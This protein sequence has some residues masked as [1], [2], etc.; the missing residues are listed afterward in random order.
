MTA[1]AAPTEPGKTAI[2][3]LEKVR[4][5]K[6][7]LEP[8][9]DTAL[10]A[11]TVTEKKQQI[12]RR[13]ERM[14]RDLGSDPLE[15][16]EVKLD[17]NFAAVLVRKIGGFDPSRLQ[18]FALALIKRDAKWTVAPVPASFENVG[19]GYAVALRKRLELLENWMLRS[20]VV[21]LEQLREQSLG[22]MRQEIEAKVSSKD[23]RHLDAKHF[24]EQ[25]LAACERKDLALMLGF[26]G[27][28]AAKLPENWSARLKAA[29]HAVAAGAEGTRPWR[30]LTA[31]EVLRVIVHHEEKNAAGL[32]SIA[33]LDPAGTG[34][35]SPAPQIELIHLELTKGDDG[36][37]QINPPAAFLKASQDPGDNPENPFDSELLEAFP[38]KW[39]ET[40]PSTPQASAELS[41]QNV[42]AALRNGNLPGLLALAKLDNGPQ[43]AS[44]ACIQAAQLWGAQHQ[45]ATV[46]HTMPLAFSADENSAVGILQFF[47][48]HEPDRLDSRAMY[49]E[50]SAS[51]WLWTPCPNTATQEKF[52]TWVES[53][54]Q[55]WSKKWQQQL[56]TDTV[57]LS[58]IHDNQA[59]TEE[60]ARTT[61]LA[62]LDATRHSD[63]EA[64]LRRIA[65]LDDP[66][67]GS[68]V[69]QN[70]GYE[71]LGSRRS[72]ENPL[73]TKIYQ[74]KTWTAVGVKI[75]Q[76]GK[77]SYP[78]Y[79][80]IQT[81][82]GPRILIEI[83]LFAAGNHGREFLNKAAFERLRKF[84]DATSELQ[85]LYSE[86][87]ANIEAMLAKPSP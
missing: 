3:F 52:K 24:G 70:L 14:A 87:Q 81:A 13:L 33:C 65:R 49:F 86:H 31:P 29:D 22:R 42:I 39:S 54:T 9:G 66:Q 71:V 80:V 68:V 8:G 60:D 63:V 53:E 61:V 64:A 38:I 47:S 40:H 10:S 7:N 35:D 57:V 58:Q 37:W 17:E 20:Q 27:G 16:S 85:A 56:L 19:A 12:A 67:S 28:L 36:L 46:S 62:W 25:F 83:D 41:H 75:D 34:T 50:K 5:R 32:L 4:L 76:G 77:S 30:L 59:P 44:K 82:S 45:P 11:Q 23:L 43:S 18:V 26:L 15:V 84:S 74:G 79:P 55:A 78:L 69:M 48:S 72:K 21:D 73:I 51:G 2:D 1:H 6:L